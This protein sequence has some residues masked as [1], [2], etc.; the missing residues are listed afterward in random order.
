MFTLI[1]VAIFLLI[2]TGFLFAVKELIKKDK[3][4]KHAKRK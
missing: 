2:V 1:K 4:K 3:N